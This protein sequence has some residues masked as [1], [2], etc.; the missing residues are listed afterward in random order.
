MHM[1]GNAPAAANN[2]TT[3]VGPDL[4]LCTFVVVVTHAYSACVGHDELFGQ[5]LNAW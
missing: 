5:V 1:A 4:G 2:T 3:T